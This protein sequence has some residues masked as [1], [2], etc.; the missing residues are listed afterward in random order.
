[1]GGPP[2]MFRGP[3]GGAGPYGG[4][5]P[6]FANR[7]PNSMQT[8]ETFVDPYRL[9]RF[10]DLTAEP[11]KTYRYRVLLLLNNPNY[12]LVAE[13]LD[14]K[15]LQVGSDKKKYIESPT[16]ETP[17]ITAPHDYQILADS[18]TAR[19]TA[20]INLLAITKTPADTQ[21]GAQPANPDT[22]VEIVKEFD[23]PLGGVPYLHD[24]EI[25]KVLDMT[26]ESVRKV[27]KINVDTDQTVLLDMAQRQAAGRRPGKRCHGTAANGCAGNLLN[28]SR[29]ADKLVLD[30]FQQRTKPPADMKESSGDVTTPHGQNPYQGPPRNGPPGL[31]GAARKKVPVLQTENAPGKA[32]TRWLAIRL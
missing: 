16:V 15:V 28:A 24:Q 27:E 10:V 20:R 4:G 2:G 7:G 5:P 21:N 31:G 19:Q 22:Y 8:A 25:D 1:M 29:A 30:D 12:N 17:A 3:P 6:G 9:F 23:L 32:F 13:C 11:G 18:I 14:P 26:T